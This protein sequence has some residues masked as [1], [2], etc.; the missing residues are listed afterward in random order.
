[1]IDIASNDSNPTGADLFYE[2]KAAPFKHDSLEKILSTDKESFV[3]CNPPFSEAEKWMKVISEVA[4]FA[5]Q[6]MSYAPVLM[7]APLSWLANKSTRGYFTNCS[8]AVILGRVKFL[9]PVT[10]ETAGT[11]RFD[12]AVYMWNVNM[13]QGAIGD[14]LGRALTE[15]DQVVLRL[16]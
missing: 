6:P 1:M 4:C 8:A 10:R 9:N 3:F 11:P 7:V 16:K 2:P 15:P 14:K 5:S 13:N 12:T